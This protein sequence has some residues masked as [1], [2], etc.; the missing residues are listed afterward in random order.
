[1]YAVW[2][3][4]N[5]G[6]GMR[7]VG[8]KLCE[9]FVPIISS[10]KGFKSGTMFGDDSVGDYGGLTVWETREDAEATVRETGPK[11]QE[12]LKD[13]V[14]GELTRRVFEVWKVF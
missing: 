3:F 13:I 9:Q 5:L 12:A 6:P 4:F 14:K 10:R 11:I 2:T 8:D 1:M 7:E